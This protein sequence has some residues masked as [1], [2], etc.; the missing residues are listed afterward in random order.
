MIPAKLLKEYSEDIIF[1]KSLEDVT[2]LSS[3]AT[4]D[5]RLWCSE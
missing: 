1:S 2:V 5:P 4:R 3:I